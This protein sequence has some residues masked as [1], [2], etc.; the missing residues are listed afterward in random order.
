M[1]VVLACCCASS[2]TFG[3]EG[4]WLQSCSSV[5]KKKNKVSDY[6]RERGGGVCLCLD[7]I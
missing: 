3:S 5:I 4:P 2:E 7:L 6:L 1:S